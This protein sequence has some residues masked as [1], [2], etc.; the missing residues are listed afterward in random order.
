MKEDH[1]LNKNKEDINS[2][3]KDVSNFRKVA[4]NI[5]SLP[6]YLDTTFNTSSTSILTAAIMLTV[7]LGLSGFLLGNGIWNSTFYTF[8][9]II[10]T[11]A[12]TGLYSLFFLREGFLYQNQKKEN[13]IRRLEKLL[14]QAKKDLETEQKKE[15]PMPELIK[16][17]KQRILDL[18][19]QYYNLQQTLDSEPPPTIEFAEPIVAD[20]NSLPSTQNNK[21]ELEQKAKINISK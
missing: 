15:A 14:N 13:K 20:L 2:L 8:I 17:Y 7:G 9:F 12:T 19:D 21:I 3:L 16:R 18:D 6:K 10:F 4:Y 5:F 11:A 1:N